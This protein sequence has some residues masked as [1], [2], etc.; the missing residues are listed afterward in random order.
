MKKWA[1]VGAVVLVVGGV[2]V[3]FL[4]RPPA[5]VEK[6]K[7][8]E[9]TGPD[10]ARLARIE[11]LVRTIDDL[12]SKIKF[13]EALA[14]VQKL[15]AFEPKEPRLAALKSRVE[16]KLARLRSWRTLSEKATAAKAD[17]IRRDAVADWQ[18]VLNLV[19]EAEKLAFT[20]E[21]RQPGRELATLARRQISW[22]NARGEEKK[23]NLAAAIELAGRAMAEGEAPPEL[24]AYKGALEKKKR[25]QE[26]D[27]VASRARGEAVSA[28]AYELW[29]E[30]KGLAD[31]P[32]DIAE[33]D[34]K[35]DDLLPR[36]DPAERDRRFAAA[37]KAGEEALV[38]GRIEEAEASFRAA[39]I[40]N[41]ADLNPPKALSRVDAARKAK[42][43]DDAMAAGKAAEEKKE[44][45][46]AIE[47][48]DRA[49]RMKSL[50]PAAQARRKDVEE[51]WRPKKFTVVLEPSTGIKMEFA[52][53]PRGSFKRGDARGDPD[54][55]VKEVVIPKD[56][57]MQTTEVTQRQWEYVM[58]TKPFSFTGSPEVPAEG[59]SWVEVQKFLVKVNE[60]V[61]DQM[62]GRRAAL[63]TEAEWEYACRAGSTGKYTFGD[64]EG[65]LED[66]AW[67][68]RNAGKGPQPVGKKQPNAWGLFDMHGNVAEWC[69]DAYSVD[70]AKAQEAE[71][72]EDAPR[73]IRG[74]SWNDRAVNCRSSKRGKDL[75][76]KGSMF[77]GFRIELK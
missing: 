47:A 25:K 44:W 32:K 46:D 51:N 23:G 11:E 34:R 72:V 49:L 13:E 53:I 74:G 50:D 35:I 12:E 26:F 62:K 15:A 17:A 77:T 1:I 57:Y 68:T 56:F 8:V 33:V 19:A 20:E 43:Y 5:V 36:V 63:P 40:L 69:A 27:Q 22:I 66:L 18:T 54:E 28:K 70:P 76:T 48:Y 10:P 30:A 60:M 41:G 42:G 4:T 64:D 3:W 71:A 24:V 67:F 31:D 21:H 52:L 58:H 73:S 6:P 65:R 14:T 59:M 75:P 2:A 16:E 55:G 37:M 61:R 39:K 29:K 9:S 7:V 38:A 45:T